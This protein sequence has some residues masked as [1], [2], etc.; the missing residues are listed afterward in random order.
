LVRVSVQTQLGREY[1][2][3]ARAAGAAGPWLV[4]RHLL[5][6]VLPPLIVQMT[7]VMADAVLLEAAF[8]FLGLGIRPP[9]PSWGVLLDTGRNYLAVAPWLGLF[10]G[11]AVTLTILAL[12]GLGDALR[13]AVDPRRA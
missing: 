5:P 7:L 11:L 1:V 2:E 4:T 10:A 13:V 12:N 6:N 8:S 9:E 3:A